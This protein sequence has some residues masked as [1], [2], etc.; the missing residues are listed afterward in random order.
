MINYH[1]SSVLNINRGS[2]SLFVF[3]FFPFLV[4]GQWPNYAYI[5]VSFFQSHCRL[6]VRNRWQKYAPTW[7]DAYTHVSC[8]SIGADRT[9]VDDASY[10]ASRMVRNMVGQVPIIDDRVRVYRMQQLFTKWGE[11]KSRSTSRNVWKTRVL[12]G[13]RSSCNTR[14][15]S[16]E[17]WEDI[18]KKK[19]EM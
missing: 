17:R 19:K 6:I 3:L 9:V 8:E 10:R 16:A 1:E 11:G 14:E 13:E 12:A 5:P 2:K 18:W 4:V 7:D 15:S